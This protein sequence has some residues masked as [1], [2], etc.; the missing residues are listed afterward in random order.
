MN[1]QSQ[2]HEMLTFQMV[3]QGRGLRGAHPQ[4]GGG[5]QQ[6]ALLQTPGQGQH[7]LRDLSQEN[8]GSSS[9]LQKKYVICV[10]ILAKTLAQSKKQV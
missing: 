9:I 7:S 8:V 2:N 1:D 4:G 5:W 3:Q 6:R 10:R